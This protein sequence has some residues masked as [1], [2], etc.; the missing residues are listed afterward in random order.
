MVKAP[1]GLQTVKR[2]ND[3]SRSQEDEEVMVTPPA[4][5][6]PRPAK[7]KPDLKMKCGACGAVSINF[8]VIVCS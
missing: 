5:R 3:H 2:I 7:I 4:P 1:S 6:K 8:Y